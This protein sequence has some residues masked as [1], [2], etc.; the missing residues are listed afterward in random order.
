MLYPEFKVHIKHTPFLMTTLLDLISGANHDLNQSS[1]KWP[2]KN[3]N[4]NMEKQ[5]TNNDN[6][7]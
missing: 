4:K 5:L 2:L 6:L 3:Q 1:T 7:S